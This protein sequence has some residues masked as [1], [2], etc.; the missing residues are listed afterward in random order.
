MRIFTSRLAM[1]AWLLPVL[2]GTASAADGL[3]GFQLGGG[4]GQADIRVDQRP[5]NIALGLKEN[6]SAWKAFV[7]VRP[8][9]LI[10]AEL[11]YFDLGTAKT[12]S[13]AAPPR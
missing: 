12:R 8:I 5:G 1:G 11:S 9:S 2:A 3:I 10:G 13:A 4:I 7:G 6:H